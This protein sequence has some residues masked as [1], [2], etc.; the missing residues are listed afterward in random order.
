MVNSIM[1]QPEDKDH[2]ERV[3]RLRK[4]LYGLKQSVRCWNSAID[5]YLKDSGYTQSDADPCVYSKL[6]KRDGKEILMLISIFV[7]DVIFASNDSNM[8]MQEK[9]KLSQN[10][11]MEDQDEIHYCLGI[12]MKR[13]R[14]TKVLTIDQKGYLESVLKRFGVSDCQPVST[15]MEAGKRFK[16][17]D[18]NEDPDNIR[19]YETA[20]R[21][22]VYASIATR[23]DL[24]S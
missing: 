1:E 19:E 5:H 8:L 20:I 24:S 22:L 4:S 17:L 16:E 6:I 9:L 21:S 14:D 11:E 15:P 12:S 10:L 3:C 7:Y 13:N 23:P 2:P 18:H